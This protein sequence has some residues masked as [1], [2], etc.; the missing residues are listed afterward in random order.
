M[1]LVRQE[2]IEPA[3][4]QAK[5]TEEFPEFK[6]NI[7]SIFEEIQ[8]NFEEMY[9]SDYTKEYTLPVYAAKSRY[10]Q[11]LYDLD[12][13]ENETIDFLDAFVKALYEEPPQKRGSVQVANLPDKQYGLTRQYSMDRQYYTLAAEGK[14]KEFSGDMKKFMNKLSSLIEKT[15]FKTLT[16]LDRINITPFYH[17]HPFKYAMKSSRTLEGSF[18]SRRAGKKVLRRRTV[19][20]ILQ[21]FNLFKSV[22]SQTPVS[23]YLVKGKRAAIELARFYGFNKSDAEYKKILKEIASLIGYQLSKV[24]SAAKDVKYPEFNKTIADIYHEL[25]IDRPSDIE[26]FST[27]LRIIQA[28]V[29]QVDENDAKKLIDL[30]RALGVDEK[31]TTRLN[32]ALLEAHDMLKIMKGEEVFI[33]YLK[34]QEVD[35]IIKMQE[36]LSEDNLDLTALEIENIVKAED[37]YKS[38]GLD[39]GVSSEVVYK[40][41]AHF[42]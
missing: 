2:F 27:M 22:G 15:F 12:V 41:K 5:G 16:I 35:D 20:P 28:E 9:D 8:D 14:E 39:Y 25:K 13:K 31:E 33:S 30:G 17:D 10:L 40:I 4:E 32:K 29:A 11:G 38:I 19:T 24:G 42:R 21:F 26:A 23:D 36:Y 6:E 18:T 1:A 34:Y 37:S 7:E 3:L